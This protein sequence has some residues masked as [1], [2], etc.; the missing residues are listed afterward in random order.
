MVILLRLSDAVER[1]P[2]GKEVH[3]NAIFAYYDAH[4]VRIPRQGG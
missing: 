3:L 2:E 4:A 1:A